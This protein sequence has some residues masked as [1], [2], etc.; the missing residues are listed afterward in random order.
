G[1]AS[2]AKAALPAWVRP[3]AAKAAPTK[4]ASIGLPLHISGL[5]QVLF[6]LARPDM[7]TEQTDPTAMTDTRRWLERAV[8][9]L[10]LCPFAK[11]PHVKGQIHYA[12]C[13][14]ESAQAILTALRAEL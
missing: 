7:N 9:G 5:E 13:E 14:D 12:V 4:I 1:A 2:A 3:F 6:G 8:I 11:A 10:N